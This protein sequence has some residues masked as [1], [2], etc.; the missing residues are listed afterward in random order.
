MI[1]V[2]P[3]AV[4]DVAAMVGLVV[5]VGA[6]F[7]IPGVRNQWRMRIVEP[8]RSNRRDDVLEVVGPIF[9][10]IRA[11]VAALR[12]SHTEQVAAV[13]A[14]TNLVTQHVTNEEQMRAED[15]ADRRRQREHLAG[16]LDE[17]GGRLDASHTWQGTTDGRLDT[18]EG[19]LDEGGKRMA[20][21][22]KDVVSVRN[23]ILTAPTEP[24]RFPA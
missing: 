24:R 21:L 8:N 19:R 4:G 1:A 9:E 22:S 14:C 23:L 17:I 3:S 13:T 16:Q 15:D 2:L 10:A 11:E 5:A 7:A 6:L 18:I 12:T 20:E